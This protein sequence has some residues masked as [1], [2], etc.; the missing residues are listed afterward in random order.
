MILIPMLMVAAW[1]GPA[2]AQEPPNKVF[3]LPAP[4]TLEMAA[5][6]AR[7]APGI[8]LGTPSGYGA[9]WGDAMLGFGFQATTRL[10]DRPDGVV[11]FAF[12]LGDARKYAGL[13]LAASSYG[14]ARTCCRG[15]LSLKL[16]RELPWDM[17]LA[18]GWENGAVWGGFDPDPAEETDAGSSVYGVVSKVVHLRPGAADPY[19]TLTFTLGAG[20]GRFRTEDDIIADRETANVFGGVSLRMSRGT[21]V[22]AD[23]TGQDL[24]A[25]FSF[26]PFRDIAFVVLPG[27]ADITTKARFIIGAGYGFDYTTLFR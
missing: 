15:G 18:V 7:A 23:W 16:H 2:T 1:T 26:L 6:G 11:T 13:E 5:R 19:R 14:T 8:T 12:G 20:N 22:V 9:D 3:Q 24:V 25:G 4:P 10:H 21:S 27:V 17:G